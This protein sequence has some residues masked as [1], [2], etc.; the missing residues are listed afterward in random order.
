M[1]TGPVDQ[2]TVVQKSLFYSL[3]KTQKIDGKSILELAKSPVESDKTK[4]IRGVKQMIKSILETEILKTD[5]KG[6]IQTIRHG[7]QLQDIA[8]NSFFNMIPNKKDLEAAVQ[9]NIS[10]N[11][12]K[13]P[14]RDFSLLAI[15]AKETDISKVEI[16]TLTEEQEATTTQTNEVQKIIESTEPDSVYPGRGLVM[17]DPDTNVLTSR[18]KAIT[19]DSKTL[20]IH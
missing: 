17:F 2:L 12:D 10:K 1:I 6:N 9:K 7:E 3:L 18:G 15:G 8:N 19:I 20:T 16:K 5:D 11:I 13:N 4:A 14:Y